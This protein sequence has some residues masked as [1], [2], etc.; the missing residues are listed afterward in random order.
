MDYVRWSETGKDTYFLN[1]IWEK[2]R[3]LD[4][5]NPEI[6]KNG[7]VLEENP[8]MAKHCVKLRKDRKHVYY[9]KI[10]YPRLDR[11]VKEHF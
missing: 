10:K 2:L 8:E 7:I 1:P 4:G 5:C 6:D 3:E 11:L 9:R